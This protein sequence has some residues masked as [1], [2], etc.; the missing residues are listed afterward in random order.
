M[1]NLRNLSIFACL[2]LLALMPMRAEALPPPSPAGGN[3]LVL[4]GVD[5]HA[6]LDF[7]TFGLLIPKD[8]DEFTFEAWIYPTTPLN[9]DIHAMVLSQQVMMDIMSHDHEEFQGL[10][11][12]LNMSKKDFMIRFLAH[13]ARDVGHTIMSPAPLKLPTNQW[14]HIAFQG[15]K[16]QKTT[17]IVNDFARISRGGEGVTLAHDAD[18]I[19]SF[20]GHPQDFT[21][22]GWDTKIPFHKRHSWGYFA[23]YIDEVR[24]SKVTRYNIANGRFTPPKKREKFKNDAKTV[25]LWHFD[26]PKGVQKFSDTSGNAYHLVGKNGAQTGGTLAVDAQ[27]KL[28]I[29]WG[30]LKQ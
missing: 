19:T 29:T 24:I 23:G 28:A 1:K 14:N 2:F 4:D 13:L 9:K 5:D 27:R 20:G 10:K 21:L 11:V 22:G 12:F 3:Y 7:E 17:V 25:A 16:G 30:R 26:E 8:T 15:G 6:I 18:K